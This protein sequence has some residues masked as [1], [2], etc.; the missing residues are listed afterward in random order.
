VNNLSLAPN[1][2]GYLKINKIKSSF[3]YKEYGWVGTTLNYDI[4]DGIFK[5]FLII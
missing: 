1:N 3:K 2:T 4:I 5:M